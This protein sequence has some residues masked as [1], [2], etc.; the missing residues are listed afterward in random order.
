M[1]AMLETANRHPT[2][3]LETPDDPQE[4]LDTLQDAINKLSLGQ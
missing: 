2:E 3:A 4:L 1:L